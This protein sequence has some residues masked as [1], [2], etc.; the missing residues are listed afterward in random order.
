MAKYNMNTDN[1]EL[2][3]KSKA[4]QKRE[5]EAAQALGMKLA[6]LSVTQIN[7]LSDKTKMSEKLHEALLAYQ[8]IKAREGRRRQLQ[9]IG[10]LMRGLDLTSIEKLLTEF[11]RGGQVATAQ[12]HKTER[13][14]ERLLNEGEKA[15][16]ELLQTYPE[17]ETSHL[18]KLIA[19]A[20]READHKQ[21]PRSAR[22]LFKYLRE[23]MMDKLIDDNVNKR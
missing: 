12:L 18:R 10:K 21:P 17:I 14:R 6:E 23:I 7:E 5:A 1:R 13:W 22:L 19:S 3:P 9:F 4:Q 8:T 16:N 20:Q 11:K 2:K 15:F